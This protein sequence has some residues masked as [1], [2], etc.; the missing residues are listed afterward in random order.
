[1]T[2]DIKGAAAIGNETDHSVFFWQQ[3]N[4]SLMTKDWKLHVVWL[5]ES[6]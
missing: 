5:F 1:M 3:H 2:Q 4:L 6:L